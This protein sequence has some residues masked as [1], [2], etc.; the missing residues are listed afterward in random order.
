MIAVSTWEFFFMYDTCLNTKFIND[1]PYGLDLACGCP[2]HPVG[3]SVHHIFLQQFFYMQSCL[4]LYRL[5]KWSHAPS[6]LSFRESSHRMCQHP[7]NVPDSVINQLLVVASGAV[8]SSCLTIDFFFILISV[9][10]KT[11]WFHF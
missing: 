9:T 3:G 5:M 11:L 7:A 8:D 6:S 2:H 10:S 4:S 1:V